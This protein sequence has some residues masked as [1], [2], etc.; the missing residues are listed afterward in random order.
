MENYVLPVI[1]FLVGQTILFL[2]AC[3][4]IYT[5]VMTRLRELEIRVNAVEKNEG[6]IFEKLDK[7]LEATHRIELNLAEKQ[8][9]NKT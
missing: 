1:L 8:D 6:E 7:L 4:A 3:V 2:S 9:R 5:R